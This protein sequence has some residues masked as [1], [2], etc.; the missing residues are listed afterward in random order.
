MK[1]RLLAILLAMCMIMGML[2]TVALAVD[3]AQEPETT[4]TVLEETA[5]SVEPETTPEPSEEPE[6]G[7]VYYLQLTHYF[8]FTVDGEEKSNQ[9][10]ET[11]ELTEADFVDGVC[12]LEQFAND[13][14]QLMVTQADPLTLDDFD[15]NRTCEAQIT[16]GVR[17]GWKVV[18]AAD[19]TANG[20][21]RRS[22]FKGPFDGY[23]FVPADVVRIKVNYKYSN[24]GGLAGVDVANYRMIEVQT[25]NKDSEGKYTLDLGVLP[26]KDGFRIVLNPD[27]LN[28][29]VVDPPTAEEL[30]DPDILA[31]KLENG[32]FDVDVNNSNKPVYYSQEVTGGATHPKYQNQYSTQYNQAWE[33]ARTLE[34]K[35]DNDNVLYIATAEGDNE[36]K[37]ATPLTNPKLK[38]T[39]TQ[40][41]LDKVLEAGTDLKITVYYRRNATWYTVNHWVP[42]NS[43][44]TGTNK[45]DLQKKASRRWR[46]KSHLLLSGHGHP[47]GPRWRHDPR[48]GKDR[49]ELYPAGRKPV[50][51]DADC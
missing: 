7:A 19:A 32:D 40:A 10:T 49:R 5:T 38:V 16:Y 26:E 27:P 51:P 25:G 35:D 41:Q 28:E 42:E 23:A 9:T 6:T 36:I 14:E 20:Q 48:R 8:Q 39:M 2:P 34:V 12:D 1:K 44:P 13:A 50:F 22:I 47:P 33:K 45:S 4:S 30:K 3:E 15:E 17:S 43:I 21:V 46:P 18:R 24:T 37:G 29:Y 11:L 31:A